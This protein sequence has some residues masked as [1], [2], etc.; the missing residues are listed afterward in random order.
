M[1]KFE[2]LLEVYKVLSCLEGC[3]D[4]ILSNS[5]SIKIQIVGGKIIENLGFESPT[6]ARSNKICPLSVHLQILYI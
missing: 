1:I 6:T 5:L 4:L 3:F 2:L